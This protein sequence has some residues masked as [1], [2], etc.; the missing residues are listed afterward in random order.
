[1]EHKCCWLWRMFSNR[2]SS[3]A[4]ASSARG[5]WLV[6]WLVSDPTPPDPNRWLVTRFQLYTAKTSWTNL[7]SNVLSETIYL[8]MQVNERR[9]CIVI[10][11][12]LTLV[13]RWSDIVSCCCSC[14]ARTMFARVSWSAENVQSDLIRH[15]HATYILVQQTK[16]SRQ[17]NIFSTLFLPIQLG[18]IV[19]QS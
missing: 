11:Y 1:M 17:N 14:T 13:R 16:N 6:H 15:T 7:Q 3:A 8:Q 4:A 5:A 9:L 12:W 18:Y 19:C 2:V 10:V